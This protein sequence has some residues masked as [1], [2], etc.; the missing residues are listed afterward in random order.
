MDSGAVLLNVS[1][2]DNDSPPKC[3]ENLALDVPSGVIDDAIR[4]C[5]QYIL[6]RFPN[7]S[8]NAFP[9]ALPRSIAGTSAHKHRQHVVSWLHCEGTFAF[10]RCEDVVTCIHNLEW[11]HVNAKVID[12]TMKLLMLLHYQWQFS[13]ITSMLSQ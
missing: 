10:R 12:V 1:K 8:R 4:K 5:Y 9:A 3:F 2:L 11:L 13:L 6:V 7:S